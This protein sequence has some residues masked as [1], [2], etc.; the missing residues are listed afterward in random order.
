MSETA[1]I[2]DL[3]SSPTT[4]YQAWAGS[5]CAGKSSQTTP[6]WPSFLVV[7]HDESPEPS[8]PF[9]TLSAASQLR[10]D[11]FQLGHIYTGT[12]DLEFL[13]RGIVVS[14][15][16]N[17]VGDLSDVLDGVI[18][19]GLDTGNPI[20]N[21]IAGLAGPVLGNLAER[22]LDTTLS[23]LQA[24]VFSFLELGADLQAVINAIQG[25]QPDFNP[26]G[27]F[28]LGQSAILQSI[29]ASVLDPRGTDTED[30]FDKDL[31]TAATLI[32]DALAGN[33]RLRQIQRNVAVASRGFDVLRFKMNRRRT[34]IKFDRIET[35]DAF[36]R[37]ING[38]FNLDW[39]T[40]S[41]IA[42]GNGILGGSAIDE[43]R[44]NQDGVRNAECVPQ[45]DYYCDGAYFCGA[46]HPMLACER[47]I[48]LLGDT[49]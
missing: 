33:R 9:Y 10:G 26:A 7:A 37:K 4:A 39:F 13:F 43:Q 38:P 19:I 48:C 23:V 18:D 27:F 24:L 32:T 20:I 21:L 17:S 8:P 3:P 14:F 36:E 11:R 30:G 5:E 25:P 15:L 35:N 47:R 31:A 6:R 45:C 2:N 28:S 34:K 22:T 41:A 12:L 49:H 44:V 16:G 40:I 1:P 42:N 29:V 46:R